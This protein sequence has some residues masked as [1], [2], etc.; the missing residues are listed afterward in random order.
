MKF[1]RGRVMG[2]ITVGFALVAAACGGGSSDEASNVIGVDKSDLSATAT[3]QAIKQP[4]TMDEWEK[5]W[6]T[7]RAAMVKAIK[8]NKYGKSADGKT[9]AGANGMA[10]DLSKCPAGWSDTEGITDTSIKI[11]QSIAQSGTLADYGNYG[12]GIDVLFKY[13]S[14]KGVFKD[15]NGKTRNVEYIQK[16]DGYDANRAIPNVDELLDSQKVFA[17]WTP[18]TPATLKVYDKVNQRCVPHPFAMTGHPAWGDPVNHPWTS[19]APVASYTTETLFWGDYIEKNFDKLATG[20]KV[21]V[22]ALVMNNDFGKVYNAGFKEYLANSAALKGKVD[23]V[24][25]QIEPQAPTITDA[26]TTLASKNPDVFIAMTAGTSCTQAITES[27]G[28]G[29]KAKAKALFQPNTCGGVSYIGKEKVGGDGAAGDGWLIYEGG[30]KEIKDKVKYANDPWIQFLRAELEKNGINPDSSSLLGHGTAY[31][32]PVAQILI[33]A[34]QL[35]GGLT[36]S[37]FLTAMRHFNMTPP[38]HFWGIKS[39]LQGGKDGYINEAGVLS[40]FNASKQLWE[41]QGDIIDLNGK[42]KNCAWDIAGA[43]CKA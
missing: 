19:G 3:T 13:Y 24:F 1:Q 41:P 30:L 12:K 10:V 4:T 43:T 35:D 11:G 5:L 8:D 21:T 34:G 23:Y 25:E 9:V 14:A 18:G 32:W 27:A 22:A 26:M 33:V 42:S 2:A 28:N 40:K 16:D 15:V 39:Q 7:E 6:E 38:T 31:G 17:V 20:G 36:R 37:N 29:M